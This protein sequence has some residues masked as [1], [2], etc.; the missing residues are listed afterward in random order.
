M[1]VFKI[2][3]IKSIVGMH[4][5][6]SVGMKLHFYMLLDRWKLPRTPVY[7]TISYLLYVFMH[8]F[9]NKKLIHLLVLVLQIYKFWQETISTSHILYC[10]YRT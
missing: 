3:D 8:D 4:V 9:L 1:L 6:A 2:N 10:L 7:F 5:S